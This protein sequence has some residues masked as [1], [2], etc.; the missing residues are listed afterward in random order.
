MAK[1][2]FVNKFGM[3]EVRD[4]DYIPRVGDLIPIFYQQRPRVTSVTWF[5]EVIEPK[6]KELNIDVLISVG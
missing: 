6:L 5:P 1:V 2:M 4:M 3:N